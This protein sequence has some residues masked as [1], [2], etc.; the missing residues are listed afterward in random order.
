MKSIMKK[1]LAGALVAAIALP[2]LII[3]GCGSDWTDDTA[4]VTLR[5]ASDAGA[6][7]DLPVLLPPGVL[8]ID[9]SITAPDMPPIARVIN[10]GG[11]G[12]VQESFNVYPGAS[13]LFTVRAINADGLAIWNGSAQADIGDEPVGVTVMMEFLMANDFVAPYTPGGLSVSSGATNT[14]SLDWDE[15]TDNSLVVAGYYVY[16]LIDNSPDPSYRV[17]LDSVPE[18]SLDISVSE[19]GSYCYSVSAI[20]PA[21]NE[22]PL[23]AEQ[24]V[25]IGTGPFPHRDPHCPEFLTYFEPPGHYYKWHPDSHGPDECYGDVKPPKTWWKKKD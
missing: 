25:T 15:S 2:V 5:L 19:P 14:I 17:L 3:K 16:E 21:G 24:C 12:P 8:Y 6:P 7:S 13:R 18:T 4:P 1:M 23:S 10:T 9:F 20:D 22:S 11:V